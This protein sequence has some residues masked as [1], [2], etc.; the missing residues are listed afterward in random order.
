VN[1][2]PIQYQLL[3][4]TEPGFFDLRRSAG[5]GFRVIS[6]VG[7]LRFEYGF[8]LDRRDGESPDRFEFTISGLF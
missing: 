6:P 7:V 4:E 3:G 8:K 1:A 2:E 5:F